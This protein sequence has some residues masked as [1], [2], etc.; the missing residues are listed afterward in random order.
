MN[1]RYS[2]EVLRAM[3]EET[4]LVA[5][6]TSV[7]AQGLPYPDNLAAARA[8]EE[9]VRRAGAVPAPIAML[10]GV[11]CIGLEEADMRR[12]AE[13]KER[14]M[15]L[16][17]RDLAVAMATKASG[18]TTV[19]ATCELAAALGI[20]VFATGG[21]GGVH[22]GA[23]EHM[24]ISQDIHALALYS[25]AVVC[26][27]AKSI[28]DLPKTLEA[29]E[30]A[31]V[32]VIGVGTD[33]LPSFYSRSSGLPLEHRV[34]SA[35]VAAR[36]ALARFE[37]LEQGGLLF[38]L[39]PPEETALPRNEVELHIAHALAEAERQ[40]IRGK[41]VTPFLLS[42]MAKR[43]GGKSLKANLALLTNNARFAGELAVAYA[44]QQAEAAEEG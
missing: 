3:E 5:L 22:R 40:G 25:V 17:S 39:P 20:R 9:A 29:L 32:P 10:D 6:E 31:G 15:K 24:D 19:S 27:G 23:S 2:Q 38:T 30:T 13:G 14:L 33:E 16:A 21:I 44:R 37:T 11:V 41:A 34:D 12:L 43:T 26:A 18:G 42:D 36:I 1:F 4:P 35:E 28:L 8:C 7:V